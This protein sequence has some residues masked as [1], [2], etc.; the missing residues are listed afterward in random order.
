M[1]SEIAVS[2]L[3]LLTP[4]TNSRNSSIK[5]LHTSKYVQLVNIYIALNA[6]FVSRKTELAVIGLHSPLKRF[7]NLRLMNVLPWSLLV[8][9]I[10]QK[11]IV[12][13]IL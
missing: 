10:F 6:V 7:R 2:R 9:M 4:T 11:K 5:S 13:P 8:Q 1:F 3:I 12:F